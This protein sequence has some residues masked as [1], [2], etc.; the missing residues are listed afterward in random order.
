M[1]DIAAFEPDAALVRMSSSLSSHAVDHPHKSFRREHSG[2]MSWPE[3]FYKQKHHKHSSEQQ[4]N[5]LS[6]RAMQLSIYGSMVC[7]YRITLASLKNFFFLFNFMN[8]TF[9][10]TK[11]IAFWRVFQRRI[12]LLFYFSFT[13][14]I[15]YYYIRKVG[16]GFSGCDTCL[17]IYE[18]Y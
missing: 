4:T 7:H 3:H 8:S 13:I 11:N 6:A 2:L 16:P 14:T 10:T 9:Q 1:F 12:H 18:Q 17:Y 15:Y 5:S